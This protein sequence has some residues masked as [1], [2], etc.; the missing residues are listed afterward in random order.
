M[1]NSDNE[2]PINEN[3]PLSI[4]SS[5]QDTE[6]DPGDEDQQS[7][8]SS[9]H[10]AGAVETHTNGTLDKPSPLSTDDISQS[11]T[12]DSL[13]TVNAEPVSTNHSKPVSKSTSVCTETVSTN[14]GSSPAPMR[15]ANCSPLPPTS[16]LLIDETGNYRKRK[17]T[18]TEKQTAAYNGKC[19]RDR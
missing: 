18:S 3:S 12:M 13:P 8:A 14:R 10:E 1:N 7:P 17:R 6:E 5:V 16:P 11:E 9:T 19:T 2:Q 15:S 4:K